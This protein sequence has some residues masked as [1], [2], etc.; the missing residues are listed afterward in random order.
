M[1][2]KT[3]RIVISHRGNGQSKQPVLNVV[4]YWLYKNK[5]EFQCMDCEEIIRE[6]SG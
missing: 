5:K 3:T 1:D 4:V 2:V 6:L